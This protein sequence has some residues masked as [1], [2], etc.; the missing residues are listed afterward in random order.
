MGK[1][2]ILIN[3]LSRYLSK[4][5]C[6]TQSLFQD[7]LYRGLNLKYFSFL[8][9]I[10]QLY[11]RCFSSLLASF[12][13]NNFRYLQYFISTFIAKLVYFFST[14]A[15]LISAIITVKIIYLGF[16]ANYISGVALIIQIFRVLSEFQLFTVSYLT[17]GIGLVLVLDIELVLNLGLGSLSILFIIEYQFFQYTHI[18]YLKFYLVQD[19]I[20]LR[21]NSQSLVDILDS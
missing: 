17:L 1:E 19:G 21:I 7:I 14:K 20:V 9:M 2:L 16:L 15:F 4:Y 5:F 3:P 6:S 8:I 11:S 10:L 18:I 13:K 12:Y